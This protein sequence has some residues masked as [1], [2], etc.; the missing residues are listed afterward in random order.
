MKQFPPPIRDFDVYYTEFPI[1]GFQV[2]GE[3]SAIEVFGIAAFVTPK[4]AQLGG[5]S[6]TLVPPDD[7]VAGMEATCGLEE[8][9]L[10]GFEVEES[11]PECPGVEGFGAT[12]ENTPAAIEGLEVEEKEKTPAQIEGFEVEEIP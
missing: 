12:D 8:A 10:T 7:T 5:I 9:P 4:D 1:V 2:I 11:R 6:L 3:S